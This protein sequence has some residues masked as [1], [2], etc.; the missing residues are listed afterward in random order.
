VAGAPRAPGC[1]PG[2]PGVALNVCISGDRQRVPGRWPPR[3]T[4]RP[5]GRPGRGGV[6]HQMKPPTSAPLDLR[7][8]LGFFRAP[9]A[10][11]RAEPLAGTLTDV[12]HPRF[13]LSA[14]FLRSAGVSARLASHTGSAYS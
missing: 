3:I 7:R 13:L 12:R 14:A 6:K 8:T 11:A 10:A 9:R 1:P 5:E 4:S 2:M